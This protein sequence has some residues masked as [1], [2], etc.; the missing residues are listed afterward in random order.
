MSVNSTATTTTTT[1][2]TKTTTTNY[3]IYVSPRD[4]CKSICPGL[5][6]VEN[7]DLEHEIFELD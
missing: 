6:G 7:A 3:T 5:L 2:A 4:I 1:T